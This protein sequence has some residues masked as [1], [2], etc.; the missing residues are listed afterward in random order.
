MRKCPECNKWELDVQPEMDNPLEENPYFFMC[1][2]CG[3]ECGK[4]RAEKGNYLSE[5]ISIKFEKKRIK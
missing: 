4:E 3:F 5:A 1:W 2:N